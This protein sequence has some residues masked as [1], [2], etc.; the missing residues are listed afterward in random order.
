MDGNMERLKVKSEFQNFLKCLANNQ[1]LE[2]VGRI[3]AKGSNT[4]T[5]KIAMIDQSLRSIRPRMSKEERKRKERIKRMVSRRRPYSR[6][7]SSDVFPF[8]LQMRKKSISSTFLLQCGSV[9]FS[10][11]TASL[12]QCR[13]QDFN[14]CD[15]KRCSGKKLSRL[16]LIKDMRVGQRFRGIVVT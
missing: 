13:V 11:L 9:F 14:H 10:G 16:G 15:P 7:Q 1:R 4:G 8:P 3:V 12:Y 5:I 2:A 6:F